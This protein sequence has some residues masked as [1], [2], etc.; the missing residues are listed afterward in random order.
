[1]PRCWTIELSIALGAWV[2]F[3]DT[4]TAPHKPAMP[5]PS[6]PRRLGHRCAVSSLDSRIRAKDNDI[7]VMYREN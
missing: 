4:P 7:F 5:L 6:S 2:R 1:M 3:I